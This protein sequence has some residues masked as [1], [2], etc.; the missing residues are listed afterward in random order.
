MPISLKTQV[1]RTAKTTV[2]ARRARVGGLYGFRNPVER[3]T[4]RKP[5]NRTL[6]LRAGSLENVASTE[7]TSEGSSRFAQNIQKG[8][9][10]R[11]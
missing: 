1:D 7:R 11:F 9:I 6:R 2:T 4:H 3:V 8:K 5:E 10:G